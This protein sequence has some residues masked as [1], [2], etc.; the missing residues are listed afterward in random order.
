MPHSSNLWVQLFLSFAVQD[1]LKSVCQINSC[2]SYQLST[3]LALRKYSRWSSLKS[4]SLLGNSLTLNTNFLFPAIRGHCQLEMVQH[5]QQYKL[6]WDKYA[7]LSQNE[8][9]RIY[10]L[11][12]SRFDSRLLLRYLGFDSD[13]G[14][15]IISKKMSFL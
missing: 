4:A 11:F 9:C 8:I 10:A 14:V 12:W 1:P 7:L 3:C 15:S 2:K 6:H 5:C 13:S